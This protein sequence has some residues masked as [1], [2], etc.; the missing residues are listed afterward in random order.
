MP[1]ASP[2]NKDETDSTGEK[3]PAS[4][5]S[6]QLTEPET[7]NL[8]EAVQ[9]WRYGV[10]ARQHG[11][12]LAKK[13]W[14][15][16][17]QKP[18]KGPYEWQISPLSGYEEGFFD[19]SKE[20]DRYVCFADPSNYDDAPSWVLRNL[21]VLVQKRWKLNKVQIMRYRDLHS[22]RDQG[23][24]LIMTL[25]TD[26]SQT[27]TTTEGGDAQPALPKITGWERNPA[28]KLAGRTVDLKE[29]MDPQRFVFFIGVPL[30]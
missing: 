21:L 13:V 29:Y 25:E 9:T 10:D 28:G 24:T 3:K 4:H 6:Q 16:A 26:N 30:I 18:L 20:G 22:R 8:V 5:A 1:T 27:S 12:F 14:V 7:V 23:R 2:I 15:A 11:F 17:D 19:N